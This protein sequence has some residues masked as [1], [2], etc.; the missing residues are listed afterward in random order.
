MKSGNNIRN[1]DLFLYW[2]VGNI[3]FVRSANLTMIALVASHGVLKP[4]AHRQAIIGGITHLV[5]FD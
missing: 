1:I 4:Q 3:C 2:L 5:A